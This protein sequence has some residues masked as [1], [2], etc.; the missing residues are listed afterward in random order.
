MKANTR[1]Y[2]RVWLTSLR[3]WVVSA[4]NVPIP[5]MSADEMAEVDR[6]VME[7][8]RGTRF[9][10]IDEDDAGVK[11]PSEYTSASGHDD[12]NS[13]VRANQSARSNNNNNNNERRPDFRYDGDYNSK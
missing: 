1:T 4:S 3:T 12:G 11:R 6:K 9:E 10:D 7:I 13:N 2:A 5:Q 8:E